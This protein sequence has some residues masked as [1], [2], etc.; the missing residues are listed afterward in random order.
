MQRTRTAWA[1]GVL[2]I[3]HRLDARQTRRQPAAVDP[4]PG[5]AHFALGGIVLLGRGLIR[6]RCLLGVLQCKLELVLGQ[7]L[8]PPTEAMALELANDLAQPLALAA[9]RSPSPSEDRDHRAG[10]RLARSSRQWITDVRSLRPV[11]AIRVNPSLSAPPS[12]AASCT[13]RQSSPSSKACSLAALRWM[14][15]SCTPGQPPAAWPPAPCPCHP[16][17][18]A[19]PDRHARPGTPRPSR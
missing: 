11:C 2:H 16:R 1:D 15:A 14:T 13:R 3:D 4:A 5:S 7:A 9:R 12:R 10:H 17:S 6:C 18:S 8:G 19:S